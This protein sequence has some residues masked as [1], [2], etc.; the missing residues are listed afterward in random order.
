MPAQERGAFCHH[1]QKSVLA[2]RQVPNHLLHGLL[3]FFTCLWFPIWLIVAITGTTQWVC[4]RC[5]SHQLDDRDDGED[6]R[7][8]RRRDRDDDR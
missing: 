7:P 4:T 6:R 5:G 8:R 1:C 3:S 2:R